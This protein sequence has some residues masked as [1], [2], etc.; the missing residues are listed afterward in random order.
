MRGVDAQRLHAGQ[1]RKTHECSVIGNCPVAKQPRK[2]GQRVIG[3]GRI[4][5]RLLPVEGFRRATTRETISVEF[6]LDDFR[7]EFGDR[8]QPKPVSP[9]SSI[10]R[11]P[12]HKLTAV[13][14]VAQIQPVIDFTPILCALCNGRARFPSVNT[15]DHDVHA[16]QPSFGIQALGNAFPVQAPEQIQAVGEN[17]RFI[18]TDLRL[19]E[20]LAHAVRRRD[21]IWVEQSDVESFRMAVCQ[22]CLMQVRQARPRSRFRCRRIPRPARA[23]CASAIRDESGVFPWLHPSP[24]LST[25]S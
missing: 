10:Q 8:S 14:V 19:T 11:L 5:E 2:Q 17:H 15:A 13:G 6:A 7:E 18:E 22:Q 16:V 4:D 12:K 20:R 3:Q 24:L 23:L 1:P 21:D 9:V 25:N